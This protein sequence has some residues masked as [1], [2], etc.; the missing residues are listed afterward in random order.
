MVALS[1][2]GEVGHQKVSNAGGA[3]CNS[4]A[5]I[6]LESQSIFSF[7]SL[8]TLI[9]PVSYCPYRGNDLIGER[10]PRPPQGWFEER[11]FYKIESKEYVHMNMYI[12]ISI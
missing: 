8:N 1:S 3:L 9:M 10:R 7:S 5:G 2:R 4:A 11:R 12:D 6:L